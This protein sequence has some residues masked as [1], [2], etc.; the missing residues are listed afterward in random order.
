MLSALQ[1]TL[2]LSID[3]VRP[4][5]KSSELNKKKPMLCRSIVL[6]NLFL[7]RETTVWG[8]TG[9]HCRAILPAAIHF[10]VRSDSQ[11]SAS[12]GSRRNFCQS[13]HGG[14]IDEC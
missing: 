11:V 7:F 9:Q 6:L 12:P 14:H 1:F 13:S 2:H 3:H 10:L 8:V 5:Y 4:V